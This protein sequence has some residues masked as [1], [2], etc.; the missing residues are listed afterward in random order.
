M[1]KLTED[2]KATNLKKEMRVTWKGACTL[3]NPNVMNN[4]PAAIIEFVTVSSSARPCC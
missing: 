3:Q 4:Q 2:Y 1:I